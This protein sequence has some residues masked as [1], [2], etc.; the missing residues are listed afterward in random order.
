[1]RKKI[2]IPIIVGIVL[3]VVGGSLSG[4]WL[5]KHV[6]KE[7]P[8]VKIG[9][10]LPLT[11]NASFLGENIK[12]G[13]DLA[14]ERINSQGGIRGKKLE[15]IYGDSKNEAKEGISIFNKLISIHRVP[16]VISAMSSVSNALVPLANKNEV[17]LFATT[18]SASGFTEQNKWTFR[19]FITADID[20]TTMA[21]FAVSKLG[22]KRI[23]ILYVNDDFGLSFSETFR[24]TFEELGGMITLLES[25]DKNTSDY[26]MHLIKIKNSEP[27]SIYL[28][29]YDNNFGVIPKQMYELKIEVPILSIGIIGQRH[30]IE[31]AGTFLKD[32]YFTTTEF[33]ADD[34]KSEIAKEFVRAYKA[35]YSRNPNYFS[36]FAYDAIN[37][38][39]EAIKRGG[40]TSKG[41][42]DELLKIKDLT[43]VM[44][45]IS[46]KS[47]RDADFP[48]VVKKIKNGRILDVE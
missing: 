35:K 44:G 32:A 3:A 9:A 11:G 26:R 1:M 8:V 47:N 39:N 2:W 12:E 4:I 17:V 6:K 14:V 45:N 48:M 15:I 21:K 7:T 29:G 37:L 30:I 28:L 13:L 18:V 22:L 24:K 42:Q 16:V 23:A 46:I 41:I 27:E 36:A 20:A 40:Y 33:L 25:F 10:I 43:G 38:L 19:L 5:V 31:Q 34:P